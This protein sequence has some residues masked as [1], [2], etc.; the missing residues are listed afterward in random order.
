MTLSF[1]LT[2]NSATPNHLLIIAFC[3]CVCSLCFRLR[4]PV[5]ST[6][7]LVADDDL[8]DCGRLSLFPSLVHSVAFV[9]LHAHPS[10]LTPAPSTML[11]GSAL[12]YCSDVLDIRSAVPPSTWLVPSA[13][14][15]APSATAPP[16]CRSNRGPL[17]STTSVALEGG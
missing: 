4:V 10:T 7:L 17:C 6:G 14:V 9:P 15:S 5:S 8:R 13:S 1:R 16:L 2:G 3:A 12:S 11:R